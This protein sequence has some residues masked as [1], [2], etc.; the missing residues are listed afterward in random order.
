MSLG[1]YTGE[2]IKDW[3]LAIMG[4]ALIAILAVGIVIYIAR[5]EVGKVIGLI[6]GAALAAL[7][8]YFPDTGVN[9]LKTISGAFA[10]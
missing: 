3:I 8:V 7:F 4:N 10:G 9:L 6:A 1:N 2:G 5:S